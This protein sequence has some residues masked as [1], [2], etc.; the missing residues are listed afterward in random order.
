V[1]I[2]TTQCE[3]F[4]LASGITLHFPSGLLGFPE[5]SEYVL[6]DIEADLP[7]KCLQAVNDP[8]LGFILIDPF[9]LMPDYQVTIEPQDLS[10]LDV[11]DQQHLCLLA[12]LTVPPGAPGQTTANLQGPIMINTENYRAKQLVLVQSPYHTRHPLLVPAHAGV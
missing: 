3:P 2:P 9:M 8:D 5:V 11:H 6:L 12:I 1:Q 10:D 7:F 4:P